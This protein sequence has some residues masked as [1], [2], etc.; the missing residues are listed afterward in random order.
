MTD[1]LNRLLRDNFE[2]SMANVHTAFPGVVVSYN[3]KTR[4][5][6]IQPS[7]RRKLPNG[8]FID[9]PII[10]E[11]PIM[12]F[13]SKKYAIH[14]P[15]EKGDEVFVIVCERS[16]DKWRDN[17]GAGIEDGDPRRF[18]LMDSI[19]IPGLQAVDFIPVEEDGLNIV[20]K[21]ESNGELISHVQMDDDHVEVKHKKSF[22]D[23]KDNIVEATNGKCTVKINDDKASIKNSSK[24]LFSIWDTLLQTMGTTSPTTLGSPATHNWNPA[25]STAISTAK[26]DL[27]TLLEA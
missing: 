26:A 4:R 20:H 21:S 6:D 2:Y 25:I 22:I 27:A 19:A 10:T 13:G 8:E 15:F 24:S 3:A 23:M 7:L 1:E 5:A 12:F 9:F 11:V 16:T 14:V 18:N 17:G